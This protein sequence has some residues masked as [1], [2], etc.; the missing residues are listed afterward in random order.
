MLCLPLI[1]DSKSNDN[2]KVFC[3]IFANF[4]NLQPY[5]IVSFIMHL[6][7][8]GK[9]NGSLFCQK[10]KLVFFYWCIKRCLKQQ[11]QKA[12]KYNIAENL[13]SNIFQ[14]QDSN[15]CIARQLT[16]VKTAGCLIEFKLTSFSFQSGISSF[17]ARGSN[18][19]PE[20][21]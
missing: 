6:R 15:S 11:Q 14:I 8:C 10:D 21:I 20:R 4:L 16:P 17:N 19:F 2:T 12:L 1:T 9:W 7:R 5:D 13:N 3:N 18:T